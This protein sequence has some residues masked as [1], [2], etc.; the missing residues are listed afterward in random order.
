MLEPCVAGARA[1][2]QIP[3]DQAAIERWRFLQDRR[4]SLYQ[5]IHYS[6]HYPLFQSAVRDLTRA[7]NQLAELER[8]YPR[9][10]YW[11]AGPVKQA[12]M[13]FF[14]RAPRSI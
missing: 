6:S 14:G 13:R 7:E 10:D 5:T 1:G 11:A 2:F 4:H 3:T 8:Q 12:L 9:M